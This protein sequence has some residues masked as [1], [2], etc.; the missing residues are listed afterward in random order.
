M[1]T[2]ERQALA[3]YADATASPGGRNWA[4]HIADDVA[5]TDGPEPMAL[6]LATSEQLQL[7]S[8]RGNFK[9]PRAAVTK[10]GRGK[11]YPWFFAAVRIH[12]N[13]PQVPQ[14]LQFK[15]LRA[16]PAEVLA[17]LRALGYPVA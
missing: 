4:G 5:A 9:L 17:E 7:T 8:T 15:P 11:F 10:L 14:N 2:N 3:Q 13:L 1:D 6:L 12:H 16:K